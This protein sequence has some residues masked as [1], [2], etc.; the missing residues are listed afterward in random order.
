[1]RLHIQAYREHLVRGCVDGCH[2]LE[3][4]HRLTLGE[5]HLVKAAGPSLIWNTA[6]AH[7]PNSSNP[8]F[9]LHRGSEPRPA[10]G[11]EAYGWYFSSTVSPAPDLGFMVT[12]TVTLPVSAAFSN[13]STVHFEVP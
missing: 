8:R 6:G 11:A 13:W 9:A 10:R 12:R 5:R 7:T 2:D 3:T 1:M 4:R